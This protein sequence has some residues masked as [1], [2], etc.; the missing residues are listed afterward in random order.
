[1]RSGGARLDHR[2]HFAGNART[3]HVNAIQR[4]RQHAK[5]ATVIRNAAMHTSVVLRK[6][7]QRGGNISRNTRVTARTFRN[8]NGTAVAAHKKTHRL[9]R[10]SHNRIGNISQPIWCAEKAVRQYD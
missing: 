5:K 3:A 9:R 6:R 7:N 2:P 8:R 1:M 10:S 4:R